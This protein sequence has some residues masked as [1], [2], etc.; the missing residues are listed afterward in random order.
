MTH[1][2][3]FTEIE[4][5]YNEDLSYCQPNKSSYSIFRGN[6]TS[7]TGKNIGEEKGK[8]TCTMKWETSIIKKFILTVQSKCRSIGK[9]KDF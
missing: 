7:D 3:N 1:F 5:N 6:I 8:C 2:T 4:D 9:K